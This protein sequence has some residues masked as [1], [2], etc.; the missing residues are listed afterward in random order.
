MLH[1][2]LQNVKFSAEHMPAL[3]VVTLWGESCRAPLIHAVKQRFPCV[4]V[5]VACGATEYATAA[6]G[7]VSKMGWTPA[8]APPEGRS[9]PGG[10]GMD[11]RRQGFARK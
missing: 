1:G 6:V 3:T 7:E 10:Q 8:K 2:M 11:R 9:M 4:H 5:F